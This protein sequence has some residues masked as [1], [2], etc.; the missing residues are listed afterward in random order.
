MT[1]AARPFWHACGTRA[2]SQCGVIRI[3]R[4]GSFGCS[5]RARESGV[6]PSIWETVVRGRPTLGAEQAK[7]AAQVLSRERSARNLW[8]RISFESYSGP[9]CLGGGA[10]TERPSLRPTDVAGDTRSLRAAG[11]VN[12]AA[13][14]ALNLITHCPVTCNEQVH[15]CR[16]LGPPPRLMT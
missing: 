1:A 5:T 15:D 14:I 12:G 10:G 9:S 6:V 13:A 2:S 3:R 8:I 16:K 7:P 11:S 4:S